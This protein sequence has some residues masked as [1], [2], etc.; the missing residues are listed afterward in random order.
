M[1]PQAPNPGAFRHLAPALIGHRKS[2][3]HPAIVPGA[4]LY[5]FSNDA[6][7]ES[8]QCYIKFLQKAEFPS[9]QFACSSSYS[10]GENKKRS[11]CSTRIIPVVPTF[12]RQL[13]ETQCRVGPP[14]PPP[15]IQMRAGCWVMGLTGE[16]VRGNFFQD[17]K[18]WLDMSSC[19]QRQT[20][21]IRSDYD[22]WYFS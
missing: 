19:T 6:L 18:L 20:C 8:H 17:S 22:A 11:L 10:R 7:T 3:G 9:L 12:P 13:R 14:K 16:L 2:L 21:A 15:R 1:S 4:G 5:Q